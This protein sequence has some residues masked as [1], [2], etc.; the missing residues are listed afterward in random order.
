MKYLKQFNQASEYEVFKEGEEYVLPNVSYVVET[1]GVSYAPKK[2][3]KLRAKYNATPDNLVAF[4][5]ATNIKSLKVNGNS[6]KFEPAKIEINNFDVLG[7][8]IS[9]DMET[10][11]ATLPEAYLI[12]SPVT[13]LSFKAKDPN[14]V[15]NEN[16]FVCMMTMYDG[17]A[18]IN[19]IPLEYV[20][21]YMFTTNDGVTLELTDVFLDEMNIEYIRYG[22][23]M[24]FTLADFN[25]NSETFEF[26][27][28]EHQ[29]N[30]TIGGLPTYS[31]DSEGIYDV[32]MELANP[33]ISMYFGETTLISIEIGDGITSI[34]SW[35]FYKCSGLTSVIIP[36]SVIYIGK[37][38]FDECLGLT[39]VH[40]GTGVTSIDNATFDGCTGLTSIVIPDSV[41]SIGQYAF[42]GCKGLTKVTIGSGVTSIDTYAF[43]DCT[44][45]TSITCFATTPPTIDDYTFSNI[46]SDGILKVPAG[47]DYSSWMHTGYPYLGYY[48]WTIQ[49]I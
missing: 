16:T 2:V 31:F 8:N 6:I 26:I 7:E 38:V 42:N 24:G 13:S 10:G 33:A 46:N 34:G 29:T 5:Y 9:L 30:A 44:S 28:T 4:D 47:S 3:F 40:I 18:Y 22:E 15:I 39:S 41:T 45:L 37:H 19:P 36:D 20:M 11:E 43:L 14:Y 23:Y 1:K 35:A 17:E 32:E 48:N 49:H 21:D 27:D 12:K 25:M